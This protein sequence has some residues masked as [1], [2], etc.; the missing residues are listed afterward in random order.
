MFIENIK[1]KSHVTLIMLSK[2][3][4]HFLMNFKGKLG[5]MKVILI[6]DKINQIFQSI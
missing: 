6:A 2:T 5:A 3:D 4:N 1:F